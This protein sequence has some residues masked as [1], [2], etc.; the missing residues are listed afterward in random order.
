MKTSRNDPFDLDICIRGL[1]MM[2]GTVHSDFYEFVYY[3]TFKKAF[4]EYY[5]EFNNPWE[6]PI[7]DGTF[8][9]DVDDPF[10]QNCLHAFTI[11]GKAKFELDGWFGIEAFEDHDPDE[12]TM[13]FFEGM[14]FKP[15]QMHFK[16][17]K[18]YKKLKL[19]YERSLAEFIHSLFLYACA[20]T[21]QSNKIPLVLKKQFKLSNDDAFRLLNQDDDQVVLLIGLMKRLKKMLNELRLSIYMPVIPVRRTIRKSNLDSKDRQ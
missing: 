1:S 8:F 12:D 5:S 17:N 3:L 16:R 13:F 20:L 7:G 18:S 14:R 11:I 19:G 4:K 15:Y 6:F 21:A 2:M 10:V 9:D